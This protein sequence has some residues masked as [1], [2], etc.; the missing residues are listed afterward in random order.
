MIPLG[1][2]LLHLTRL[3]ADTKGCERKSAVRR[4]CY[5][6]LWSVTPLLCSLRILLVSLAL[7]SPCSLIT[8][9]TRR[10]R[11][12]VR[13]VAPIRP[14]ERGVGTEWQV[15]ERSD[16]TRNDTTGKG[17]ERAVRRMIRFS[18]VSLPLLVVLR[19]FRRSFCHSFTIPSAD[20]RE[21][22]E[23]AEDMIRLEVGEYNVKID[24]RPRM[25]GAFLVH[26]TRL[27][28]TFL[29]SFHSD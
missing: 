19:T 23:R 18:V 25:P 9:S 11:R 3:T 5:R 16:G 7:H 22:G 28:V 14:E 12:E 15:K 4:L 1:Q 21:W 10:L 13:S 24:E 29:V 8:R 17:K 2:P 20:R 27:L 26:I 6:C